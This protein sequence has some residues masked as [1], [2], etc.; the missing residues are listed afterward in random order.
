M[1]EIYLNNISSFVT[2]FHIFSN[3]SIAVPCLSQVLIYFYPETPIW[4]YVV[5]SKTWL[6]SIIIQDHK[7]W[8]YLYAK[9]WKK[10]NTSWIEMFS[11][12]PSSGLFCELTRLKNSSGYLMCV[13]VLMW[14]TLASTFMYFL[15]AIRSS[16]LM[17]MCLDSSTRRE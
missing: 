11:V 2:F 10:N 7:H 15:I 9:A 17:L 4:P 14:L 12:S 6:I 1:S 3:I 5:L 16:P 8:K 13:C